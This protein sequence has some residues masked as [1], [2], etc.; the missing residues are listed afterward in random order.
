MS[1][2]LVDMKERHETVGPKWSV[3]KVLEGAVEKTVRQRMPTGPTRFHKPL[4]RK[5]IAL[6]ACDYIN[7]NL[8]EARLV[9]SPLPEAYEELV[10]DY[11]EEYPI[12]T[13]YLGCGDFLVK[14]AVAR[15]TMAR[16]DAVKN[17]AFAGRHGVVT[18]VCAYLG[19]IPHKRD[20]SAEEVDSL[21][22]GTQQPVSKRARFNL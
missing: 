6:L 9:Y 17:S 11:T 14:P 18:R 5:T 16:V 1:N 13:A 21:G 12:V 7:R 8:P 19:S 3:A 10:D 20:L 15:T 4:F 22:N 2:F